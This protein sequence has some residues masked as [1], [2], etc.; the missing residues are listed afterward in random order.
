MKKLL[1]F[2]DYIQ[3]RKINWILFFIFILA[4]Q[5]G[6][7][8]NKILANEV[9][10]ES[11]VDNSG[12][13]I[14][15]NGLSATLNSYGGIAIGIGQ[16]SGE[17]ELAFPTTV[18][19]N[20]TSYIKIDT[21]PDLLNSL[22]GGSLG[23][24][25]ADILGTVI[26][27]NHYFNI[28]ARNGNT[29]VLS[30]SSIIP[31]Q[32][33]RFRVVQDKNGDF[34]IAIT[35]N[36]DYNRIYIEDRTDALLLG[37]FNSMEVYN[38][39]YFDDNQCN[40]D[41]LFTDYDGEGIT[42][43]IIQLGGA[44]VTDPQKVIDGDDDT[45]S[46]ISLGI[47]GVIA[48]MEQNVYFPAAYTPT[49]EFSVTLKTDPTLVTLGLLNN[50]SV[51]AYNGPTE[52]FSTDLFSVLNIDLLTLLQNGEKATVIF[53]PGA[54]FDRVTVGLTSL[55]NVNL[56]QTI[57]VY[58]ISVVGPAAPTT[59]D[60]T[61]EF[62]A[63][64]E[65]TIADIQINETNIIWYD[66]QNGG[67]PYDPT[68]LL[69]DGNIYYAAQII[70]GCESEERLAVTVT[71]ND[72]PT[73]TTDDDTQEFCAVD[74]P[75][76]A[77]LQVNET[78]VTWYDAPT[79]GNSYDPT[80][81]LV[82]SNI[83][84][85]AELG[86]NG[87]ESAV[88]LAVTVTINDTPTPTTDDD[89][90][91]FC[92]V[93]E[94]TIADLQAVGTNIIWYDAPTGGNP[95]D[96]TDLL[97]SG[98]IYYAAELGANGCESAV[99]LAVTVTIND[100]PTPT[101]DDDTQEFCAVDEPTVADLQVNETNII[102]YDAPTGGNPYDP[103]D[104]LVSGNIYYAAELGANGCEST[105]RLAVTVTINDTPIPTT[106]DDT[107]EFCAVD[108]PTVAD[109][110][111]NET[112]VTWY[113]APTNGNPYD[114]TDLLVDG[115]IYYAAAT[116]ANGCESSVRLEVTVT[117]NDTPTPT[118]DD[119]TQEFCAVDQ[120]TVAD[121]QAVG[122]NI[123]W[124]D[125]PTGGNPYDPTDLL[126]DGNIY[127][128]A[129][130]GANGCE[131][132][133]RLEVT[134]TINDTPAPTTDDDT[135]EF[136]AVDEPTVADLQAVG[137][138][139]IWYDTPTGGNPYDPSDLLVDGNI[140]YAAA[141]GANG[142]ESSVRLE[143]T[144]TINDTPTPTT[145]DNTQEFCSVN[146]PTIANLQALGANI[147]WY[148]APTGGNP[149]A[150]SDLLVNG[151]TYYA[152][153]NGPNG[154]ESSV[155]L[156][157]FVT[158]I[159]T[160]TPTTDDDTQEFCAVDQPTVADLDAR[161]ANIIWY[162]APTGGNPYNPTDAL[163]DG[164]IY[165]AASTGTNGCE[166]S[167]R[168]AVIVILNNAENPTITSDASGEVCLNTIITY[169]TE[170][171]NENYIWGFT[172][173]ELVE[174]GSN[175]DNFISIQW[176]ATENNTVEVSYDSLNGCS[177]GNTTTFSETI[178]VCADI[179]I[180]KTVDIP[181]PMVG[182]NVVFTISVTNLGPNDFNNVEV[183]EQ[184]PSGY[185]L[186]DF[187]TTM[188]TYTPSTGVWSIDILP[189]EET[190][191]L[192]ITAEVLGTGDYMNTAIITV[193]DPLDS[194]TLNNVSG[195]STEPLCLF[196][197]NE[198]SPNDDGIN[199]TFVISCIENFPNNAIKIF[200]RYGSLVYEKL[201]YDNTWDGIGNVGNGVIKDKVLPSDTYYYILDLGDGTKPK[202]GWLFL[203]K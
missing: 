171:G 121:L 17:L 166:S 92:A 120:P 124:Y 196:V 141:T 118:T 126:V 108:E 90:Q 73:P 103:T 180:T 189:A 165:Y 6:D 128:A 16:F 37:T 143:V 35:P 112:N 190:A 152:A 50:V 155:R 177:T 93:D 159:D 31:P 71:I 2:Q 21:D 134:V 27:G 51:T 104:L 185:N 44:G 46:E 55:L 107:Q 109:L 132:S 144:V 86:A 28:E 76:V 135:Q 80:D 7:A 33:N 162:D 54:S 8:Q 11:H 186:I 70:N 122:T 113:D 151:N 100:T 179:T 82:D 91:E 115:N 52:V 45:F 145:D 142:C 192:T 67:N 99:R 147:V 184:I 182:E 81:L 85:A 87:C 168:L 74:E 65:P 77:D 158:I 58:D 105:V 157:V 53:T 22:L 4:G 169:T 136:C 149:Y 36:A 173:G 101:T 161:G 133:V 174:G 41:P 59:D 72:T 114:P 191:I 111:V 15:D 106:D 97:V 195:V 42:L 38:A 48:S 160:T 200:N 32:D 127:Y 197:Y 39:F 96:P 5:S 130:R 57:D 146:E 20:T 88:R 140:Y 63:V 98:N 49:E 89:T 178:I 183:S 69:V 187:S 66:A 188:G 138:N 60:D 29:T 24:L 181:E 43:D 62:C 68:D 30:R 1:H 10:F 83:Y 19:A 18:P 199:D 78:N 25:L 12:N 79:N 13:A 117:I 40:I 163:V 23:N 194:D 110:Q 203:I 150:P 137:T 125:A 139:I 56:M 193:S 61:Q 116:G 172:G 153:A 14:L 201:K 26:F 3:H 154:C 131:S 94:P 47:I 170:T 123:I 176:T 9:T 34:Y 202:N 175:I 95:Y 164:N 119:D 102:W 198:F 75:T 156:E 148:D 64:D 84:Y 129:A 167:E